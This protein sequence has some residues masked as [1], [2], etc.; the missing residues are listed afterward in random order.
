[1]RIAFISAMHGV[2]WGGSEVLWSQAAE[3]LLSQGHPVFASAPRWPK[4]PQPIEALRRRGVEVHEREWLSASLL[5]RGFAR[6]IG[7][8]RPDPGWAP[9]WARIV[10]FRPDLVCISHGGATCGVDWMLRCL[11]AGIP[12]VSVAQANAEAWW[13]ADD[14]R[15]RIIEAYEGAA[16]A[17]FVSHANWRLLERQLG[18]ALPR[19]QVVWNPFN[20]P[21]EPQRTWPTASQEFALACVARLD[22]VAKGQDLLFQVLA[23]PHWRNRPLR[24]SLFGQGGWEQGLRQLAH[25]LGVSSQIRFCGHVDDIAAVWANHHALVLPSRHEGLPLCLVEAMLCGRLGIVTDVGGN[26]EPLVEGVNG[27]IAAAPTVGLLDGAMER[28]WSRRAEWAEIG[29]A[30]STSIRAIVPPDPAQVFAQHLLNLS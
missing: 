6:A 24:V 3:R 14:Q 8:T 22:P 28:A 29:V 18:V 2:P 30:A 10:G 9:S 17:Y 20:V 27:F 26:R 12:Y 13:P 19:G 15:G 11:R 7:K 16:K 1:M 21:W 25:S 5:A 23:L 4:T